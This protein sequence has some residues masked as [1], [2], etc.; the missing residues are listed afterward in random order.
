MF[1]FP[2]LTYLH[3]L[4]GADRSGGK[5]A[6]SSQENLEKESSYYCS[7]LLS[8]EPSMGTQTFTPHTSH[9]FPLVPQTQMGI[10][11]PSALPSTSLLPAH[12]AF[13]PFSASAVALTRGDPRGRVRQ[14]WSN[15]RS[16]T[17]V[18]LLNFT[19]NL[20]LICKMKIFHKVFLRSMWKKKRQ[21][22]TNNRLLFL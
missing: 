14:N 21:H 5:S 20:F 22:S 7:W 3:V 6:I 16:A 17:Y 8:Y 12:N 19:E 1:S 11:V 4:D 2:V 13:S 15:P 9:A 10:P 18:Q